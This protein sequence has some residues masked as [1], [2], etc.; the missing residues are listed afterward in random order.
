MSCE[1]ITISKADQI[2]VYGSSQMWS[3]EVFFE[4]RLYGLNGL[5]ACMQPFCTAAKRDA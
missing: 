5:A 1:N 2:M 4:I 3:D